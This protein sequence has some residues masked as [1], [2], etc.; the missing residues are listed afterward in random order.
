MYAASRQRRSTVSTN[1]RRPR[2]REIH[3]L[4]RHEPGSPRK[5]TAGSSNQCPHSGSLRS[6]H[7]IPRAFT[8]GSP[9]GIVARNHNGRR[10]RR[11]AGSARVPRCAMPDRLHS[12]AK[13]SAGDSQ[14]RHR[15]HWQGNSRTPRCFCPATPVSDHRRDRSGCAGVLGCAHPDGAGIQSRVT[16]ADP[17]TTQRHAPRQSANRNQEHNR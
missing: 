4:R 7:Y 14:R 15:T 6:R 11:S 13:K 9:P 1:R 5:Q 10:D 2:S 12:R 8:P 3:T 16:R 17:G